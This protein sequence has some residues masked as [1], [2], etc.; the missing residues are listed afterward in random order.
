MKI[1]T[2]SSDATVIQRVRSALTFEATIDVVEREHATSSLPLDHYALLLVDVGL[3]YDS[4]RSLLQAIRGRSAS[5]PI[6][7][8][9]NL[10]DVKLRIEALAHGTDDYLIKPFEPTELVARVHAL[11]RPR[12]HRSRDARESNKLQL[13]PAQ[14]AAVLRGARVPLSAKE[15]QLL[16]V[17]M[18]QPGAVL[19][20]AELERRVY[21]D[22]S[23]PSSNAVEVHIHNLR[24]KLGADIITNVR[25]VG[26]RVNAK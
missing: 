8:I 4:A 5:L 20:V 24:K 11:L 12:I 10:D 6:L 13:D 22:K 9:C 23:N 25:G 7:I 3:P 26:Y 1:L 14:H 21:E 19:S 18:N 2:V 15:F 16:R 17:L